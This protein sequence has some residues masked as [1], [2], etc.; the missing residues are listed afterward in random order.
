MRILIPLAGPDYFKNGKIKG[1]IQTDNGPLLL[2]V[3]KSRLWYKKTKSSDYTFIMLESDLARN[4]YESYLKLWLP[5]CKVI[6]LSEA[7]RGAAL[8]S[9]AGLSLESEFKKPVLIDLADIFFEAQHIPFEEK[10]DDF[11]GM[12]YYF[13]SDNPVYSYFKLDKNN[14][15]NFTIEKKVISNCASAGVYGF[16]NA[17]TYINAVSVCLENEKNYFYNSLLY[18][19]PVL[20]GV[21]KNNKKVYISKVKKVLDIKSFD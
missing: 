8:S 1:L 6:Y 20:N 2:S 9:L 4:F 3:I 17:S 7:S 16:L 15:V 12:G 11:A 18:V 10:S 19:C 13:E 14:N 21:I 5:D